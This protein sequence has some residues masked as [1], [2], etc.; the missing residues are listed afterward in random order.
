MRLSDYLDAKSVVSLLFVFKRLKVSWA[1]RAARTRAQDLIP[2]NVEV[3]NMYMECTL[4]LGIPVDWNEV[5]TR[6][7]SF[8]YHDHKCIW[9]IRTPSTI[10]ITRKAWNEYRVEIYRTT[11]PSTLLEIVY[12]TLR[13]SI[14]DIG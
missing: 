14:N 11:D 9:L 5:L 10:V 2:H 12:S 1:K 13:A 3:D 4:Y 6:I 8:S 7:P